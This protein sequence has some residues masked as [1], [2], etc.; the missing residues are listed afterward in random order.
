MVHLFHNIRLYSYIKATLFL[1][2]ATKCNKD[3]QYRAS[4]TLSS[5]KAKEWE[6]DNAIV[7]L[8]HK[9]FLGGLSWEYVDSTF[10]STL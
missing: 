10:L 6:R 3:A 4:D 8:M 9:Q 5:L 2:K 7:L 1:C